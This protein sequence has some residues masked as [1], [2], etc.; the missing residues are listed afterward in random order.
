MARYVCQ[1][2]VVFLLAACFT[3]AAAREGDPAVR[4][5]AR[6]ATWWLTRV[7]QINREV[8][9][10]QP[11]L[12]LLGDSIIYGWKFAGRSVWRRH[13][14]AV[15]TLNLGVDRD[16]IGHVLWRIQ[17][18]NLD[19]LKPR[20]VVLLVGTNNVGRR[21]HSA[22]QVAGGIEVVV[23]ELRRRLPGSR[24]LLMG[25]LPSRRRLGPR[26][27]KIRRINQ[28]LAH[29]AD[30]KSVWFLDL[31]PRLLTP[32]R[33]LERRVSHDGLHLTSAGYAAWAEAMASSLDRLLRR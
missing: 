25:I 28:L 23:G 14:G 21:D 4:P 16:E 30:G 27:A 1:S 3:T 26:R 19:G 8:R 17:H 18:G 32:R 5:L 11:E 10:R 12:V 15:N 33:E 29:L 20:V 6:T 24:V 31:S 2:C 7:Q 13:F 9:N 22:A